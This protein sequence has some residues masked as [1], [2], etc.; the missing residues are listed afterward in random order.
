M[1]EQ[2]TLK[3][4]HDLVNQYKNKT[5]NSV[6]GPVLVTGLDVDGDVEMKEFE[7]TFFLSI[8]DFIVLLVED[9][10]VVIK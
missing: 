4:K 9:N 8:D 2:L 3:Q 7:E 1:V 10:G 6:Y 5:L